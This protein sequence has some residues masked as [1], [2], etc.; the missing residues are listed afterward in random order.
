LWWLYM[1]ILVFSVA[2][3]VAVFC[4]RSRDRRIARDATR[5]MPD[6]SQQRDPTEAPDRAT[7]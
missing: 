4:S 3:V 5:P 7:E 1:V 6:V 2:G